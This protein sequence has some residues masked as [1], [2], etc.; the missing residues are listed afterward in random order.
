MRFVNDGLRPATPEGL[1]STHSKGSL[2]KT[3]FASTWNYPASREQVLLRANGS[4]PSADAKSKGAAAKS[5]QQR[6]EKKPVEI[7]TMSFA[8]L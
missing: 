5:R 4:Y 7:E 1:V 8:G 6:I 3:H 2:T